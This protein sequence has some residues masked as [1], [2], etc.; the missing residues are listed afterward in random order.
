MRRFWYFDVSVWSVDRKRYNSRLCQ[1]SVFTPYCKDWEPVYPPNIFKRLQFPWIPLRYPQTPLRLLPDTPQISPGNMECQQTTTDA[2]KHCQTFSNS[3]CQF[4]GFFGDVCWRVLAFYVPQRCYG[5][6][7][8][9]FGGC[10]GESE[11]NSWKLEVHKC[12]WGVY[13]FSILAVWSENTILAQP[14]MVRFFVNWPYWDIK[15]PK[16]PHISLPKMIGLG[17]FLQFLGSSERYYLL[18]LLLITLYTQQERRKCARFPFQKYITSWV[19]LASE[20]QG[21]Q[22]Q[23]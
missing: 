2:K 12:V 14:W 10:L 11:L 17:H 1:N 21:D 20:L 16:P 3:T 5:V 22:K 15:I 9:M 23:L 13:G 18:Q 6:I 19:F 4:L 8:G 7:G